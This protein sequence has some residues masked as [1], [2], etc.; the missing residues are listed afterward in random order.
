[1]ENMNEENELVDKVVETAEVE[2]AETPAEAEVAETPT[3]EAVEPAEPAEEVVAENEE[4]KA[5]NSYEYVL[6]SMFSGKEVK[7]FA[8]FARIKAV[9][10]EIGQEV[11]TVMENGLEETKNVVKTD[12][13]TGEPGWIVT[14]PSGEQYIVEN[15]VFKKKYEKDPENPEQYKPKGAPVFAIQVDENISFIAPWG[16]QMNIAKGGYLI[17]NAPDDIY[18]IQEKEFNETYKPTDKEEVQ[19]RKELSEQIANYTEN[20]NSEKEKA[21]EELKIKTEENI[22]TLKDS[23][24]MADELRSAKEEINELAKELTATLDKL[25]KA[26]ILC[27]SYKEAYARLVNTPK[28]AKQIKKGKAEDLIEGTVEKGLEK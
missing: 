3:E 18:G 19:C 24:K 11:V 26:E 5:I 4:F 27:E 9:Q 8:K 15:S 28:L 10:G 20:S 13:E 22:K 23:I 14:N 16:E 21:E 12:E 2:N 17:I 6:N 1:M 7:E 25:G